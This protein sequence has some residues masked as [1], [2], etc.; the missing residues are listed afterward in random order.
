MGTLTWKRPR[1]PT[2]RT[3]L[4]AQV[5]GEKAEAH[6]GGLSRPRSFHRRLAARGPRSRLFCRP[7]PSNQGLRAALCPVVGCRPPPGSVRPLEL[8]SPS[9]DPLREEKWPALAPA[10]TSGPPLFHPRTLYKDDPLVP[11]LQTRTGMGTR[12][13]GPASPSPGPTSSLPQREWDTGTPTSVPP[14]PHLRQVTHHR[15]SYQ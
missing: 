7:T 6:R 8:A 4:L 12:Q 9:L 10:P 2:R 5:T 11:I 1:L 13:Y 3:R 15:T 14:A